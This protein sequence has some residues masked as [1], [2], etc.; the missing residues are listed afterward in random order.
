MGHDGGSELRRP[1]TAWRA[2][3]RRAR[4]SHRRGAKTAECEN[5]EE[6]AKSG[7][8]LFTPWI[9]LQGQK[10]TERNKDRPVLRSHAYISSI[11]A[12]LLR[13]TQDLAPLPYTVR[14]VGAIHRLDALA[15]YEPGSPVAGQVCWFTRA[16]A[17]DMAM[18]QVDIAAMFAIDLMRGGRRW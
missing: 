17:G 2:A 11:G 14:F 12:K 8:N 16:D 7:P 4:L 15:R 5:K 13:L 10:M 9:G 3:R 1:L 18:L 6:I